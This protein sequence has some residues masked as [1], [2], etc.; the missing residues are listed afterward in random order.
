MCIL[1]EVF[2]IVIYKRNIVAIFTS[3]ICALILSVSP[4]DSLSSRVS[5]N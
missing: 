1:N 4:S 2:F 3:F 5:S